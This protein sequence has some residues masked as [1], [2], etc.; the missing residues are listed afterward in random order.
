LNP[1]TLNR[2][3]RGLTVKCT[4]IFDYME[5]LNTFLLSEN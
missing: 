3:Y 4:Q 5:D 1:Q 2:G